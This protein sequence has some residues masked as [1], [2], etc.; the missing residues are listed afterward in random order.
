MAQEQAPN[1]ELTDEELLTSRLSGILLHRPWKRKLKSPLQT[2]SAEVYLDDGK[3]V[4]MAQQTRR[5]DYGNWKNYV[6]VYDEGITSHYNWDRDNPGLEKFQVGDL[7]QLLN[8]AQEKI[9]D[10]AD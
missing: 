1:Q 9:T 2:R 7:T 6:T 10:E 5:A 8:S 3:F 4:T